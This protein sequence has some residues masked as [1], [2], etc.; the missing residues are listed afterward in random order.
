LFQE[1]GRS[2]KMDHLKSLEG[3]TLEIPSGYTKVINTQEYA[4]E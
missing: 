1:E 3:I 2:S 4:Y